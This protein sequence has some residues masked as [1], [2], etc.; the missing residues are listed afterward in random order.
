MDFS[1]KWMNTKERLKTSSAE[2]D[3]VCM[4]TCV[5]CVN[6]CVSAFVCVWVCV[7]LWR[8]EYTQRSSMQRG[9]IKIMHLEAKNSGTEGTRHP[10]PQFIKATIMAV[11]FDNLWKPS[12][13]RTT[14][15]LPCSMCADLC[16]QR[17]A[18]INMAEE[19][20]SS[21][22]PCLLGELSA[23]GRKPGAEQ[24]ALISAKASTREFT[25]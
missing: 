21:P 19:A 18:T 6:V 15:L 24:I 8:W 22:L 17:Q 5:Q 9:K 1:R 13:W 3:C 12:V 23:A 25:V 7:C 2:D 20:W 11:P 16:S 10:I 14:E 4:Y